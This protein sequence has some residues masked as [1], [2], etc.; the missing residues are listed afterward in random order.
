MTKEDRDLGGLV[1]DVG[2]TAGR[3]KAKAIQATVGARAIV[4]KRVPRRRREP[5][6]HSDPTNDD[7]D[8]GG[9]IEDIGTTTGRAKANA[10]RAAAGARTVVVS[11]V[12]RRRAKP[13]DLSMLP[14][15]AK[16]LYCRILARQAR[17][18]RLLDP[19][20]IANL[21]LFAST[22]GLDMK[23]RTV[24]RREITAGPQE[25]DGRD[26]EDDALALTERLGNL[27]DEP[28]RTTVLT[29][30][31]KDLLWISRADT[32][33]AD[34]EHARV[35][36]I[37]VLIFPDTAEAVVHETERLL[38]AEE[39]FARGKI[40]ASQL[41][42]R[43]KDIVAAAA[44]LGAPLAALSAAG[45]GSGAVALTSGLAALGFGGVLGFSAMV[46]GIGTVIILGVA[47][48]QGTRFFLGVNERERK[49]RH[50]FLVQQ[51]IANHQRAI[52]DL[53]EDIAGLAH[54]MDDYLV[55]ATR[56]EE[57]LAM[58]RADLSS[59]Q[60]ALADLQT[61]EA[62]ARAPETRP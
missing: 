17:F 4:E 52:A 16:L 2:A 27:L 56:N 41:E 33:L 28:G 12:P 21:Y 7:S 1:E 19:R 49:R 8:L 44:G 6:D 62:L 31:M 18:D 61:R 24:L 30:L 5:I 23:S 20:E 40:T 34:E 22:I 26:S 32:R 10:I 25:G 48:Y 37:A 15:E 29:M 47:V 3:A 46:T 58:L 53:T 42:R 54:R 51:V 13:F 35:M 60:L 36:A 14:E 38:D 9:L 45:T 50:E 55:Q 43:T 11:R 59:F 57:R 39:Q